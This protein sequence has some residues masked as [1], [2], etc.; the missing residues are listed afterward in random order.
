MRHPIAFHAEMMGD[1]M[2]L[3]QALCQPD[4]SQLIDAVIH[5]VNGHVENKHRT[6][7]KRFEVPEDADVVPSVWSMRCKR[8][9]TTNEIKKCKASLNL[10]GEKQV[11]VMNYYEIYAPVMTWFA[12]R[13]SLLSL[14][15]FVVGP[16]TKSAL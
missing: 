15:S 13:H 8:D 10:H 5:E 3:Q 16:C 14:A 2:Y 12:I 4:A 9:I 7:I 6:L 1:I 11:F